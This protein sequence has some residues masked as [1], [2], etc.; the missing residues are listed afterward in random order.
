MAWVDKPSVLAY[1]NDPTSV[2]WVDAECH[3][4]WACQCSRPGETFRKR[5]DHKFSMRQVKQNQ[6]EPQLDSSNGYSNGYS[7]VEC[8][9]VVEASG[10]LVL[11]RAMLGQCL[12]YTA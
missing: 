8:V 2:D 5:I 9:Q 10:C 3:K 12:C 6:V 11:T 1:E 4:G 7:R